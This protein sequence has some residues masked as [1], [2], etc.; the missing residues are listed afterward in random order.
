[1]SNAPSEFRY[2]VRLSFAGEDRAYVKEVAEAPGGLADLVAEKLG[3][4]GCTAVF[5]DG[6][7]LLG[8]AR[9]LQ[10]KVDFEALMN[11]LRNDRPDRW[12]LQGS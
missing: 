7:W 8:L 5:I 6:D 11:G 9:S 4:I 2:D 1:M 12:R 10:V 3:L